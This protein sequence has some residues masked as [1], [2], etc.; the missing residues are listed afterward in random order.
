MKVAVLGSGTAGCIFSMLACKNLP[1][2][3]TVECIYDP[4][5][6]TIQVGE[7]ASPSILE[8]LQDCLNF[9]VAED[10]N[11]LDGT[12]RTGV[13]H[14]W[15]NANKDFFVGYSRSFG[16]H[17]NST[18]FS[19][20]VLLR[21][22][23]LYKNKFIETHATILEVDEIV[24]TVKTTIKEETYDL[25]VDARGFANSKLF[26]TNTI[27]S[28]KFSAVNSVIIWP[29][30]KHYV[31]YYT[32]A[33]IHNNGWMFGVPLTTRKAWGYLY[34]NKITSLEEAKADFKRIKNLD[35]ETLNQC[36]TFSWDQYYRPVALFKKVL[37]LGNNLYFFEPAGAIPL[38]Y[39]LVL[40]RIITEDLGRIPFDQKYHNTINTYHQFMMDQLQDLNALNY[41]GKNKIKSKF[42]DISKPLAEETLKKSVTWNDWATSRKAPGAFFFTHPSELMDA[43]INGFELE[44]N[45]K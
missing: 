22:K 32:T 40:S 25:I 13:K 17:V 23:Q 16:I 20:F 28:P 12:L 2:G 44:M 36:R 9:E 27:V 35:N 18:K 1:A 3:W 33:Q 11:S 5:I 6:P 4:S 42:W 15:A 41:A 29:E 45:K 31:E 10:L 30:K 39:Y 21:L 37:Y 19:S 14:F 8:A 26:E 38:H 43:Y 34:N 7:T 24:G